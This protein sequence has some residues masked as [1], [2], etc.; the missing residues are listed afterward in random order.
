MALGEFEYALAE[1]AMEDF[2]ERLRPPDEVLHRDL[3]QRI[4]EFT[5]RHRRP[6]QLHLC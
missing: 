3:R 5:Q 6:F 4:L 1:V 2:V